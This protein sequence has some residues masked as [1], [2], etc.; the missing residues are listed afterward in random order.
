MKK[1]TIAALIVLCSLPALAQPGGFHG[2]E[3][4][5]PPDKQQS[6]FKGSSDA[7]QVTV[8]Q[9]KGMKDHAW[10]TLQGNIEKKIGGD[11]YMFRDHTGNIE[12]EI[13]HDKWNGQDVSPKDLVV[14]SGKLDKDRHDINVDVEHLLKQ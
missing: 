14:I 4:P 6:G 10:V 11:K 9:A 7:K 12:V 2:D 13:G 8:E 3:T 5:P 1:I